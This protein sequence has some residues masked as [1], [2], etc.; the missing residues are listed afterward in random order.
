IEKDG[1]AGD[2][3]D[4]AGDAVAV[5]WSQCRQGL[6][7]HKVKGALEKVEFRVS[8]CH[9]VSLLWDYHSTVL[10]HL[11]YSHRE[12]VAI[13]QV[14]TKGRGKKFDRIS[15]KLLIAKGDD[16]VDAS[17]AAGGKQGGK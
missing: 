11:W 9:K 14:E 3:L 16:G 6:K 12:P 15:I 13:P 17:G 1:V 7:D 10:Q 2:L 8:G 5:L 4:A